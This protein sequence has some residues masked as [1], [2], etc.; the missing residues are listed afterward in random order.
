MRLLLHI[1]IGNLLASA[2]EAQIKNNVIT[3]ELFSEPAVYEGF[4]TA[5]ESRAL[6]GIQ[7]CPGRLSATTADPVPGSD[8][9]A[10]GTIYF[11]PYKGS[12]IS[13]Y[14]GSYWQLISFSELSLSLSVT[15]GSNYD[16]F[17]Y[18]N[19][20]T[21]TLELSAA[22]TNDT[23]R[24]TSLTLQDGVYVKSGSLTRRY[25]GTIRASGANVTEDSV[26]KRFVWSYC[27]RHPRKISLTY[28]T[29]HSYSGNT[30]IWGNSSANMVEVVYGLPGEI[31][32]SGGFQLTDGGGPGIG[33]LGLDSQSTCLFKTD[34]RSSSFYRMLIPFY[35]VL[36]AGYHYIASLQST[37]SAGS[38]TYNQT[39]I[40]GQSWS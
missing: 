30:R 21:P 8:L 26:T 38:A 18:S 28:N 31:E 9:T 15:S 24:A 23:T 37:N 35:Q 39:D 14:N 36:S 4:R 33:C 34:H 27:N 16:V 25:V 10:Q 32:L 6:D 1:L 3:P 20:G 5:L 11:T 2:A 29:A 7:T 22:W 13:L 19:S 12:K 40:A 17:V